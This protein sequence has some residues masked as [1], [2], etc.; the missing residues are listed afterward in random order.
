MPLPL[1]HTLKQLEDEIGF[2]DLPS[3][4]IMIHQVKEDEI[5]IRNLVNLKNVYDALVWLKNNNELYHDIKI[6]QTHELLFSS[7]SN[8]QAHVSSQS[9]NLPFSQETVSGS[10]V[11]DHNLGKSKVC[12]PAA[13]VS[14]SDCLCE[15][16]GVVYLH[17]Q[18]LSG[19]VVV[20]EGVCRLPLTMFLLF[21]G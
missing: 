21:A 7:L 12:T 16:E 20:T 18:C 11:V 10:D 13:V 3:N 14:A 9:S 2:L 19:F 6:P 17:I 8:K 15:G 1:E 5:L 4:Y